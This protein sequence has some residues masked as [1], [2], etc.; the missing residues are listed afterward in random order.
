[1]NKKITYIEVNFTIDIYENEVGQDNLN[2]EL[3]R[4]LRNA[5]EDIYFKEDRNYILRDHIN[6]DDIGNI[7]LTIHRGE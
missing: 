5:I 7:K 4:T 6:G 3:K 1:M 2:T